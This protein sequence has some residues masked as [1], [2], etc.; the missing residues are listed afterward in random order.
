[1]YHTFRWGRLD[2]AKLR[3]KAIEH[4]D[5]P[6]R[7]ISLLTDEKM[8]DSA[9]VFCDVHYNLSLADAR[10]SRWTAI[11]TRSRTLGPQT[12]EE[13]LLFMLSCFPPHSK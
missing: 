7:A 12:L 11:P 3:Q 10:K 9:V 4:R 2:L 1:M 6:L 13:S 8:H 5:F